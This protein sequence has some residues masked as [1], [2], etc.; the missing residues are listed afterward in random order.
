MANGPVEALLA[1]F[2]RLP[3][4]AKREAAARILRRTADLDLPPLSD[5]ALVESAEQ[6]FLELDRG[7]K[8]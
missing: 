6:V 1:S 4:E 5:E 2:E 7:A 8:P 3:V